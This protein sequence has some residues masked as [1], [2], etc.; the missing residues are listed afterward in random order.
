MTRTSS[1]M[2]NGYNISESDKFHYQDYPTVTAELS[3]L[4][5]SLAGV[6]S[7][8]KSEMII[9]FLKDHRINSKWLEGNNQSIRPLTSGAIPTPHL[10]SLFNACRHN[11]RFLF[12]LEQYI[13]AKVS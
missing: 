13:T 9:S 4:S 1:I 5:R 7:S 3:H 11:K 2:Q 6:E 12:D 10:E 8:H